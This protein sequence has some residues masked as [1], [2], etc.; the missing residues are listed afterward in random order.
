MATLCQSS[1]S[2]LP[3]ALP[4]GASWLAAGRCDKLDLAANGVTK[5]K[6]ATGH[7]VGEQRRKFGR[8]KQF[9]GAA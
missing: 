3:A 7:R 6:A 2:G 9:Y 4:E 5:V 1:F 8:I